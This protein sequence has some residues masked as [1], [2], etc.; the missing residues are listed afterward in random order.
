MSYHNLLSKNDRAIVAYLLAKK[1]GTPADVLTAKR[2][3]NRPK[4]CTV[5]WSER[6]APIEKTG[7]YTASVSIMVR[8]SAPM[9]PVS[10]D[11]AQPQL[12]S[13]ARVAAT[14][15]AMFTM[16]DPAAEYDSK[17]VAAQVTAAARALAASDPVHNADLAD[18]TCL[19]VRDAGP[20]A[21]FEENTDVWVDTLNLQ[22]DCCP[23]DVS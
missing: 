15:D 18:Y 2:S 20:E 3:A 17:G 16:D 14:F 13:D 21:S 23:S 9:D 4:P 12:D 6:A 11:A 8:T 19:D 10:E 1:V 7:S 5:V 22:V